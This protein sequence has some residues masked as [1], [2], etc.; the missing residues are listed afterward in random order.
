M[1]KRSSISLSLLTSKTPL[2]GVSGSRTSLAV[3]TNLY[4]VPG[5]GLS[6]EQR[7]RLTLGVELVTKPSILFLD[8]PTSG[9]DGQSAFNIV[10]FMRRLA[11]AGQ[12]IVC[13]IHQ[14]SASLFE[15]FDVLL[16]LAKGGRTTYFGETGE[17]SATLLEYFARQGASCPADTNPAEYMIDAVQGKF[18]DHV[19]WPQ[20]WL[21]SPESQE[22][23]AEIDKLNSLSEKAEPELAVDT[24]SF[25]TPKMYQIKLV[26]ERQLISL[27][28]N[29]DYVWN[30]I[31]LHVFASLFAGFTFWMIGDGTF[32]LQLRL[33]TIF[34]F[35]FVAPGV[36]NQLQPLFLQNREIFETREKKVSRLLIWS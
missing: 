35:V 22:T 28:R 26:T 25:A 14:P 30:K 11:Q 10:R 17:N 19:D 31:L 18:G 23:L 6:I 13:T 7:K 21:E 8:E 32:D 4:I 12:A 9:L 2:L 16:L 1:L 5:A 24:R 20:R 15:A 36:I 33:F 29:P 34:N 3:L 27:W